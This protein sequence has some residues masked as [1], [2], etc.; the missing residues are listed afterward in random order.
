LYVFS[1]SE[2][3]EAEVYKTLNAVADWAILALIAYQRVS[4]CLLPMPAKRYHPK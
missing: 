2:A 4:V 3:K 1:G